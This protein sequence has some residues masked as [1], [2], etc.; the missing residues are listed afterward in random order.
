MANKKFTD[1][2]SASSLAGSDILA[3]TVNPS[4]APATQ[5]TTITQLMGQAPVQQSDLTPLATQVSLGQTETDLTALINLRA[6]QVSLSNHEALTQVHGI[7]AFG[8]SLVDDADAATARTTLNVD[9]AGT[10]NSTDVTLDTTS[11]D[12]L[13]L[14]GQ[15]VSLGAIDL[16]TDVTGLLPNTSVNGLGTAATQDVGT[17]NGN[18]V[19]LDAT[20]LPA[21]DGSQLTNVS[22]SDS[23]KL[24]IANNLSDL[25]DAATARTNL[26][27]GTAAT[28]AS[29]AYATSAQGTTAD[30]ATQPG[31]NI[32]TLTNDSGFISGLSAGALSDFDFD[33]NPVFGFKASLATEITTATYSVTD[34]DNGKVIRVNHASGCTVTI[35][36][37]LLTTDSSGFNCSF[38]QVGSGAITFANDGTSVI[39]NRQSHIKT[40]GQWAVASVISTSNNVFVLAG[41]TTL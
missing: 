17:A 34:A 41:D 24:A 3:V 6:T 25:N 16:S 31:D 11:H 15:T 38:I 21:V 30:S 5:S 7:S 18:V 20:G 36:S 14:T 10:D 8:A 13:S 12:Y 4:T 23:T 1:L 19:Q 29:T 40:N 28:T 37:G 27:L 35:P 32:S 9:V 39:N 33:D 26:G 22:G 2:I